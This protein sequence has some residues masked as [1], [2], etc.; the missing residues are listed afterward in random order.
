MTTD[1]KEYTSKCDVCLAHRN[2]Q[3]REP[4]LQHEFVAWPWA[5]V[6]ADLCELDSRTLLVVSDY[7]SNFIEVSR[8]TS[9]TSRAVIRE[10]KAIFARFG[11]PDILVTDNGPQ[12]ASAEY[13]VFAKTWM[14]DHK[15]SSPDIP[16][17]MA[18]QRMQYK[19]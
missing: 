1:I 5:K 6:A 9:T 17:R 3:E 16:N 13:A 15:T 19:Q 8:A 18:R 10:L 11:I 14:F 12:F 4:L 2:N 7:Y